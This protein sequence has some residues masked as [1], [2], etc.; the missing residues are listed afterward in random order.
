MS[1]FYGDSTV[2]FSADRYLISKLEARVPQRAKESFKRLKEASTNAWA[3]QQQNPGLDNLFLLSQ[4]PAVVSAVRSAWP[5][6]DR[7]C[8]TILRTLEESLVISAAARTAG[9]WAY[10]QR[11]AQ[12]NRNNLAARLREE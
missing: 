4:D 2:R 5:N 8:D 6:P 9:G 11:R 7:E 10:S 1:E 3:R 12:W